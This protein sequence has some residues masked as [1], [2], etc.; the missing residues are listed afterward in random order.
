MARLSYSSTSSCDSYSAYN[1]SKAEDKIYYLRDILTPCEF[2]KEVDVVMEKMTRKA[3]EEAAENYMMSR[4]SG[5]SCSESAR[6][7]EYVEGKDVKGAMVGGGQA[8]L[9]DALHQSSH[10][11]AKRA[12]VGGRQE[13]HS[14]YASFLSGPGIWL[15]ENSSHHQPSKHQ[16]RVAMV[17]GDR[18][19]LSDAQHQ[20]RAIKYD[21][22]QDHITDPK[23]LISFRRWP[24][25]K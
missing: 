8:K 1:R 3:E 16:E 19:Q 12:M 6:H 17:G 2:D 23:H 5:S 15:N 18:E 4:A 20:K 10:H 14:R 21:P 22:A 9:S 24:E 13:Q 7:T 25:Q 11:G